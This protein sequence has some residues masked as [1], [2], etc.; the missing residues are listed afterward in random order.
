VDGTPCEVLHDVGVVIECNPGCAVVAVVTTN[1]CESVR[2]A[3]CDV[4][5]LEAWWIS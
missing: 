4:F 3:V 5:V 1:C 2:N